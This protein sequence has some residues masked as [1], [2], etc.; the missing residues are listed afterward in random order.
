VRCSLLRKIRVLLKRIGV[1]DL[2]CGAFGVSARYKPPRPEI[3]GDVFDRQRVIIGFDQGKIEKQKCFVL[4]TG[5]IG[6]DTALT[7]ARLGVAK[8]IMLDFDTLDPSNL[9]R[10]C[11]GSI[12]TVGMKKVD[13]AAQNIK[14]HNLRSKIETVHLDALANWGKV[15]E[16]AKGCDVIFNGAI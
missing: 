9:T 11:L 1:K 4:G 2:V 12:E 13:A 14:A 16:I 8:I 7:L 3:P 10:Q 6:Q 5:G 15:V